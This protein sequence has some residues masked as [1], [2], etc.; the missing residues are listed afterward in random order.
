MG[1]GREGAKDPT[2]LPEIIGGFIT[3]DM[4][5]LPNKKKR[6]SQLLYCIATTVPLA[7]PRGHA[8]S[9]AAS[10]LPGGL[11]GP[12]WVLDVGYTLTRASVAVLNRRCLSVRAGWIGAIFY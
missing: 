7:A 3:Q 12:F 8:R 9:S 6:I 2:F 4:I 10:M 1:R 5:A 11:S